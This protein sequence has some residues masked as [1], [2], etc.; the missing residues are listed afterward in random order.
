MTN[1]IQHNL[2]HTQTRLKVQA[3][4]H[5]MEKEYEIGNWVYLKLQPYIQ[6]SVANGSNWKLSYKFYDTYLITEMVGKVDYKLQLP[7]HSHI[8]L[9]VHV[10]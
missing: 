2:A 4:K 8:H 1:V 7:T 6:M 5:Q 3:N 9:V 10:Y